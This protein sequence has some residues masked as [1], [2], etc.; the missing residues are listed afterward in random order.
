MKKTQAYFNKLIFD[1]LRFLNF[2]AWFSLHLHKCP[3]QQQSNTFC[4]LTQIGMK[5]QQQIL[6]EYI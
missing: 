4:L 1:G 3:I 2:N 5:Y 6:Q